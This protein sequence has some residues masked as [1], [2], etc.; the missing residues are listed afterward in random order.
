MWLEAKVEL[1]QLTGYP[2]P[3]P[4]DSTPSLVLGADHMG[5]T[6]TNQRQPLLTKVAAG[7]DPKSSHRRLEKSRFTYIISI[8]TNVQ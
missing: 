2:T 7:E 4:Y 1:M 8:F 3:V 5:F 6:N